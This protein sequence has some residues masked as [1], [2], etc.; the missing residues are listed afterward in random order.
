MKAIRNIEIRDLVT[1]IKC[2]RDENTLRGTVYSSK[3][4]VRCRSLEACVPAL[5]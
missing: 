3:T 4:P 2:G 5:F 1:W